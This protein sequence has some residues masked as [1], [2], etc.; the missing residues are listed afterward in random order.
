MLCRVDS[1]FKMLCLIIHEQI[2]I[3]RGVAV[4]WDWRFRIDFHAYLETLRIKVAHDGT[5]SWP[6][7]PTV[8]QKFGYTFYGRVFRGVVR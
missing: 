1:G 6:I 8:G 4:N 7:S 2:D 5:C 3:G